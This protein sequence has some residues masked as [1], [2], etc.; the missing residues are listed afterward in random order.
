MA[1]KSR[2]RQDYEHLTP[3]EKCALLDAV[4]TLMDDHSELDETSWTTVEQ[5]FEEV[6][7]SF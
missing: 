2:A 7:V 4:F 3:D 1:Y 6:G 5:Y